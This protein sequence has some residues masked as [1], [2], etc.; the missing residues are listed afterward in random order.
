MPQPSMTIK[1]TFFFISA[2]AN[3][4]NYLL[5]TQPVTCSKVQGPAGIP[6]LHDGLWQAPMDHWVHVVRNRGMA[7]IFLFHQCSI[8]LA[9][10]KKKKKSELSNLELTHWAWDSRKLLCCPW[11]VEQTFQP[12]SHANLEVLKT[13]PRKTWRL[14]PQ[15]WRVIK[16][17]RQTIS[18]RVFL[19]APISFIGMGL[20]LRHL[21]SVSSRG[22]LGCY[23]H[24]FLEFIHTFW[25][26]LAT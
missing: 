2:M 12:R 21:G 25:N 6:P 3:S 5:L 23:E 13:K 4:T 7:R 22:C 18:F 26:C 20:A 24:R 19:R 17:Q 10:V 11:T 8:R 9:W 14:G 1:Q 16:Q 15:T